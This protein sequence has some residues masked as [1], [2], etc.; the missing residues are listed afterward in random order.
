MTN[1]NS[2][3]KELFD[4]MEKIYRETF[5]EDLI[6]QKKDEPKHKTVTIDGK[7]VRV[8]ENGSIYRLN[9][10]GNWVEITNLDLWDLI[11]N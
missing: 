10:I 1:E 3:L 11:N 5:N 9:G 8:D 6:P 2:S 7:L 4:D